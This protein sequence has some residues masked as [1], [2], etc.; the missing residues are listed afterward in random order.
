MINDFNHIK[1]LQDL[2]D[3]VLDTDYELKYEVST[4][5]INYIQIIAEELKKQPT[6]KARPHWRM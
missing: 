4:Q 2:I 3:K 5:L 6:S 1:D